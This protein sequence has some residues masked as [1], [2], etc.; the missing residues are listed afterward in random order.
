ML[1]PGRWRICNWCDVKYE[2]PGGDQEHT[3]DDGVIF[4]P[5][6]ARLV[7]CTTL[8]DKFKYGGSWYVRS[9]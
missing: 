8:L 7:G 6:C 3:H 2:P 9:V 4:C 1:P 5:E